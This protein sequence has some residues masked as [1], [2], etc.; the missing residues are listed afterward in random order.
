M[1]IEEINKMWS[2]DC[3]IDEANLSREASKIPELH[4]K[5]YILY[6]KAGLKVKKLKS[7]LVELEKAKMEYYNGSM[8]ETELKQRG[9]KP[10]PLKI[11]RQ[12][13]NKYIE[14]DKDII[15]MSLNIDY[16]ASI[17]NYLEDI[18]RQVNN[19]NFIITNMIKWAAFQA[20]G[21]Y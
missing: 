20:G 6:V 3:K 11:L 4:N 21:N 16:H 15:N 1:T 10:N 14:S 13:V 19:R 18:I 12:D 2:Q 5:Y 9:W 17:A 8:D 7:E